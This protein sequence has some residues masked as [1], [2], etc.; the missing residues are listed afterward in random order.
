MKAIR[1][2]RSIGLGIIMASAGMLTGNAMAK[3]LPIER[4]CAPPALNGPAPLGVRLSPDGAFIT[5]LKPEAGGVA[6]PS[7]SGLHVQRHTSI[8]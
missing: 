4:V 3:E 5:Y 1:F 8:R 2:E 6:G 7:E